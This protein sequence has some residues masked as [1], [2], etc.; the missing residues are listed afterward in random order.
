MTLTKRALLA[1]LAAVSAAP[2]AGCGRGDAL[3]SDDP[4]AD[5]ITRDGALAIAA[6]YAAAGGDADDANDAVLFPNG[7]A[8]VAALQAAAARDFADGRMFVHAGWRLSHTE[9]RLF[10]R[11]AR[12]G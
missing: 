12:A 6:S 4:F 1:A 2:L 3:A 5:G 8:D 7:A 9:G 10:T 11:L